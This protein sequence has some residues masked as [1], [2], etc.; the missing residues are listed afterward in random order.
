MMY[1]QN[2][3]VYLGVMLKV[4]ELWGANVLFVYNYVF[5][6]TSHIKVMYDANLRN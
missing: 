1:I 4:L 5:I 3:T 6:F 2:K